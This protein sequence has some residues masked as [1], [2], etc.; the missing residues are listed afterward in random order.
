MHLV[1]S[2][3]VIIILAFDTLFWV[4]SWV[5]VYNLV[6]GNSCN[7]QLAEPK[8]IGKGTYKKQWVLGAG[9]SSQN[10]SQLMS[11]LP[12]LQSRAAAL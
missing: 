4:F 8:S 5:S 12:A 10:A 11:S 9:S 1:I 3:I 6:S 2:F 7:Y